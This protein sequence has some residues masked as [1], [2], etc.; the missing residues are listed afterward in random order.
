MNGNLPPSRRVLSVRRLGLLA[1]TIAGLG[2]AA[3]FVAPNLTPEAS[4]L[5]GPA[6]A[7]NLSQE[8]QKLPQRPIGFADIVA[9]VKPA[10]ISVRV[11]IDRPAMSSS[12]N[13]DD[14][15]F[16]PGSPMERFF[17][18][19][20][21]PNGG[22]GNGGRGEGNGGHHVI[23]GQGSGFF[24]TA[25]GYAVTNN[26]VVQNADN[27]QVTTDDGK[28][29]TAKV[30]GTDARTDLAL[31]KVDGKD[32]PYVKLADTAPRI[33]DWV[34]AVGNPFG[35]GGT[36]TAGIVSAR[37][38]DIGAG[39][40]DDFIQIDAPVNK[41]NSGGPTFDVDGNVIGV[42]TAIFSPS[43]GSV[44]IAF[45][46]PADTV[47]NVVTQLREKGSVTRGWIGVQIQP[48]TTEIAEGLGLKKAAGALVSEPQPNS[49]AAK[50]GI[51]SGDVITAVD[52]NAVADARELARR[53]G[54]M[55][56][57][58]SVKLTVVHQGQEKTVTLT[59]GTLPNEKAASNSQDNQQATPDNDMPKLGLT[60]A[61]GKGSDDINGGVVVTAVD[62]SGVAADHGFQVG[63]VILD[64]GG[65]AVSS[66][67]DVRK[68]LADARKEGKHAL[69][70]R[71]KSGEGTRFVA[72]P[73]GN[74]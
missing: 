28:T 73:L 52:G 41:G 9:K 35:L 50:A 46:I 36:V 25:D 7:Q 3:F 56:P 49:P 42:N 18:R 16:P 71:V 27:V 17:R 48:V 30:I 51:E 64:V 13:E 33:G 66:P 70:F 14:N 45:D 19:F 63:D 65:K 59:L 8:A 1:T 54:T 5:A 53:I 21:M 44:G 60:L 11:K 74:A 69:L 37:G 39:P 47:K 10:V 6:H 34:L 55:A 40:Y 68:Q 32:F 31:I 23:T 2:A 58:T 12:L 29:H 67:A 61:P 15:P 22:E 20:G 24:I 43:G 72:L 38:R 26:H 4:F 57:G 62:P